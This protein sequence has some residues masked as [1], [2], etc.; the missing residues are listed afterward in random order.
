MTHPVAGG[1]GLLT[2][3]GEGGSSAVDAHHLET[4]AAELDALHAC[5]KRAYQTKDV[6]AYMDMFSPALTYLQPNGRT[7]GRE[8]LARDIAAQFRGMHSADTSYIRESL[9][10]SGSEATEVLR[11]TARVQ[12]VAFFFIRRTWMLQRRGR[13]VW[14]KTADGWNV[15]HVEVLEEKVS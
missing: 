1:M 7:I 15:K 14:E 10:L 5:A 8:R 12:V 6:A 3:R 2:W 11:Q 13:Y 9:E 4:V